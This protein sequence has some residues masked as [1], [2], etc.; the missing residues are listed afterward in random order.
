V[1]RGYGIR[2]EQAGKIWAGHSQHARTRTPLRRRIRDSLEAWHGNENRGLGTSRAGRRPGQ[3]LILRGAAMFRARAAA[4]VTPLK[5]MP[6]D[7]TSHFSWFSRQG[8]AL[9]ILP[10]ES[11]TGVLGGRV[12]RVL[13]CLPRWRARTSR[14][15][16]TG[17]QPMFPSNWGNPQVILLRDFQLFS[18]FPVRKYR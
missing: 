3:C 17:V 1:R 15:R 16:V 4:T 5:R 10:L 9:K 18:F 13:F 11:R 6:K 14:S 12:P 2:Y 8:T 7:T